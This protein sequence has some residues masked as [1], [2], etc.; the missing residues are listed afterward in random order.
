MAIEKRW[1]ATAVQDAGAFSVADM[2]AKRLGVRQPSGATASWKSQCEI[3]WRKMNKPKPV[4]FVL[5]PSRQRL[6]FVRIVVIGKNGGRFK[7]RK[8]G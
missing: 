6:R 7:I 1:R 3:L 8:L 5:K 4:R 2:C